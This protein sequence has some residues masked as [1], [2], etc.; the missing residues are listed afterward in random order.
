MQQGDRNILVANWLVLKDLLE[1]SCNINTIYVIDPDEAVHDAIGTLLGSTGMQ[2]T[3]F[4][5]AEAFIEAG[6]ADDRKHACLLME[7]DLP[8][9]GSLALVRKLRQQ[10]L[11]LPVIVLTSTAN[12]EIVNQALKAGAVDVFMKPLAGGYLL[13]RLKD[14][15]LHADVA[16]DHP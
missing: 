6:V 12:H 7:A 10:E 4:A 11:D 16:V 2:V 14:I 5:T 9:I 1:M 3:C 15:G 13:D 8:G